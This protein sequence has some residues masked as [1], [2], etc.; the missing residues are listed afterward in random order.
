MGCVQTLVLVRHAATAWNENRYCQGRK[1]VPLSPT[2]RRQVALLREALQ[3]LAFDRAY[4]SPLSRAQ[5]TAR[6][7][8]QEPRVLDDLTEIDRGHWEGHPPDEIVRRWGKLHKAWL[9]YHD[10]ENWEL[11]RQTLRSMGR[12]NLIGDGER[13]L[14]PAQQ[15]TTTDGYHAKRRKNTKQA[16]QPVQPAKRPVEESDFLPEIVYCRGYVIFLRQVLRLCRGR[17]CTEWSPMACLILDEIPP[18]VSR[19]GAK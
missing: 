1:D 4:A 7:L 18:N 16:H 8:G 9:R 5:E 6:L 13:H 11:I 2:G 10:P 14:V 12:G 19:S 15:P 17:G 3:G